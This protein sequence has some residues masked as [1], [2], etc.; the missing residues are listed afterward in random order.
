MTPALKYRPD[1]TKS[2]FADWGGMGCRDGGL[3]GPGS[4]CIGRSAGGWVLAALLAAAPLAAAP[5]R[6]ATAPT[7]RPISSLAFSPDGRMLAA[8]THRELLL[9]DP[10]SGKVLRRLPAPAGPVNAAAF[11]PDGRYLAEAGGAPGQTGEI[12]VWDAHTWKAL[13][14]LTPHGDAVYGLAFSPDGRWLASGSYDHDVSLSPTPAPAAREGT[15]VARVAL[16]DHT[17]AVYAVAFSPDGKQLASASGD[18]TVKIWDVMTHRRL[19]TLSEAT[20][21]L[22]TLAYRPDGRQ[23][24]A[25]GVDR[26]VRVWD[27]TDTSGRL[28]QSAFAHEGAVVRLAYARDGKTLVTAGEDRAV[29]VWDAALLTERAHLDRQSDWPLG[30]ALDGGGRLAVGRFDG[31]ATLYDLATG[32]V[33]RQLLPPPERRRGEGLR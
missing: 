2:A 6:R 14:T 13:E 26:M 1:G 32:K 28:A 22:Y 24:A 17:D 7:P 11:D 21:E 23:L 33:I 8:G 18:R 30:I 15:S 12:R 4:R 19:Y 29:K 3:A 27:V 9:L 16:K 25:G 5:G 20:A 31:S 10:E